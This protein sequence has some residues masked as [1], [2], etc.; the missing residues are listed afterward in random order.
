MSAIT[1]ALVVL[2][3]LILCGWFCTSMVVPYMRS[4]SCAS[5]AS[6][7]PAPAQTC[8]GP[9]RAQ[10]ATAEMDGLVEPMEPLSASAWGGDGPAPA[11][12]GDGRS[13]WST[14]G[15]TQPKPMLSGTA[16][17]GFGA[18]EFGDG[19]GTELSK[20][21]G[22]DKPYMAGGMKYGMGAMAGDGLPSRRAPGAVGQAMSL[23]DMAGK[24]GSAMFIEKTRKFHQSRQGQKV[25]KGKGFAPV[26]MHM[27]VNE[28]R[29]TGNITPKSRVAHEHRVF[30]IQEGQHQAEH[31][32]PEREWKSTPAT[33]GRADGVAAP[34]AYESW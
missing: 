7:T 5:P 29:G 17:G 1:I 3:V 18:F 31:G 24:R 9:L 30:R 2:V 16:G 14:F 34:V 6:P 23:V 10:K 15:A 33:L 8:A 19:L 12:G 27:L 20:D 11:W 32:A 26:G 25:G 22:G 4:K 13:T 21:F 28:L